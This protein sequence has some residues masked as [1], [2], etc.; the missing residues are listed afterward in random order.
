[1]LASSINMFARRRGKRGNTNVLSNPCDK[2]TLLEYYCFYFWHEHMNPYCV[3]WSVEQQIIVTTYSCIEANHLAQHLFGEADMHSE[4]AKR[5]LQI[6]TLDRH[7]MPS[8]YCF[9]VFKVV[10]LF[11]LHVQVCAYVCI[12]LSFFHVVLWSVLTD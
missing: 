12:P 11:D 3:Q 4:P 8:A 10:A 5:R 1:M 9:M 7:M 6:L 2:V